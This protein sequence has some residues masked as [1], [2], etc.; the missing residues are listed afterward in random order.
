MIY[1]IHC[2]ASKTVKIGVAGD[3]RRRIQE[4]QVGDDD[5]MR[6]AEFMRRLARVGG[7]TMVHKDLAKNVAIEGALRGMLSLPLP[8]AL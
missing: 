6:G 8:I 5:D 7:G 1:F 3:P 2:E 4:L